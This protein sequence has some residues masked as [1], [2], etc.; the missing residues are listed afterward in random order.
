MLLRDSRDVTLL[1][2]RNKSSTQRLI[3]VADEKEDDELVVLC[4]LVKDG[5]SGVYGSTKEKC[6]SCGER[7]W[8]SPATRRTV[9]KAGPVYKLLCIPCG[10]KR[11]HDSPDGDDK[12]MPPSEEQLREIQKNMTEW[13]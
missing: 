2:S 11:L 4:C 9:E 3:I 8:L 10:E 5:P 13:N 12:L 6:S 1:Q 7:I